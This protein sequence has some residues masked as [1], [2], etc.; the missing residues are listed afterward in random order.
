MTTISQARVT[1]T[2]SR[3][4]SQFFRMKSKDASKIDKDIFITLSHSLF[5][6]RSLGILAGSMVEFPPFDDLTP[7][8]SLLV[9]K[10]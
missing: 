8:L 7:S 3:F 6:I 1:E 4:G 2:E 5:L 10:S 9:G